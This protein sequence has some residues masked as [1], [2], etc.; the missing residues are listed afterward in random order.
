MIEQDDSPNTLTKLGTVA[1]A[2][3]LLCVVGSLLSLY[4]AWLHYKVHTDPSFNSFCAMNDGFNCE[5]VA[6][7][8][9]SVFFGIP[10]SVWGFLGYLAMFV[11]A[12]VGVRRLRRSGA[13]LALLFA[14]LC[15][16]C[17]SSALAFVSYCIICSFC[18]FCTLTYLINVLIFG[19]LVVQAIRVRFPMRT[20]GRDLLLLVREK[21]TV[22]VAGALMVIVLAVSFPRYWHNGSALEQGGAQRGTTAEGRQWLGAEAPTLV[23]HE[24]SDYLCPH[25][26]RAH[27]A[28]RKLVF[29]NPEKIRLVHRHFPLDNACNPLVKMPFH[30]GAC[31]LARA[32]LCAGE[33]ELFWELNDLLYATDSLRGRTV[34]EKVTDAARRV[35]LNLSE[36]RECLASTRPTEQLNADIQE[37]LRLG[38]RG[39][40][41]LVVDGKVHLGT[42]DAAVL[43]AHGILQ[44]R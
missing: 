8:P 33:Q 44:S 30:P 20:A 40:P 39:T 25:C 29:A 26:R 24:F 41:S 21:T 5:T 35:G 19:S 28:Q 2:V 14:S 36:F 7:S 38:L 6:E 1:K 32:G 16:V 12:A 22:V 11:L 17:V 31:L 3:S 15:A 10:V 43:Q 23:I 4:L 18:L 37:G 27:H 42:V 9:Y 34:E 13:Y